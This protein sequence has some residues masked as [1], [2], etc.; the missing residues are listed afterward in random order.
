MA[1]LPR[2][3]IERH[4]A[5]AKKIGERH[6]DGD[7]RKGQPQPGERHR[8]CA[9]QMTDV[10]AVDKIVRHL[11]KLAESHRDG[12]IDD[13]ARNAADRKIIFRTHLQHLPS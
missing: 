7:D 11:H 1:C 12:E 13:V 5:G 9:W 10:D 2:D 4:A 8:G 6:D 3:R